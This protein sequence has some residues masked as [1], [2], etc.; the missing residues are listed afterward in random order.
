[1]D[2]VM[3][4]KRA[5]IEYSIQRINQEYRGFEAE[6]ATNFTKQDSIILN[7]Q[8]ACEQSIDLAKRII[9]LKQLGIPQSA[10]DSFQILANNAIISPELAKNLQSMVGFRNIAIHSYQG[11]SIIILISIINHHLDDF[12]QFIRAIFEHEQPPSSTNHAS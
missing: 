1:M 7:L 12:N 6:T 11:I 8:R 5:K 3:L 4:N 10:R 2:D 9:Q